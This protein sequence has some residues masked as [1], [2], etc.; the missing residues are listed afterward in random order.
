MGG[1]ARA[2]GLRVELENDA[3]MVANALVD[4]RKRRL[5]RDRERKVVQADIGLAVEGDRALRVRDTPN[6]ESD[7]SIGDEYGR[8]GIVAGDF[9]EAQS[10]AEKA[11]GLVEV[12]NRK[13]DMVHAVRQS[14]GHKLC[15][16]A[17]GGQGGCDIGAISSLRHQVEIE[18]AAVLEIVVDLLPAPPP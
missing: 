14:I 13:A 17:S 7:G 9:L 11:R 6:G 5:V 1:R 3:G 12:A 18:R 16:Q 2:D 10:P 8:I 4:P 15:H